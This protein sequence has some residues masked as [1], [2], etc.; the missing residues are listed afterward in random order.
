[1]CTKTCKC[2]DCKNHEEW[3]SIQ[4]TADRFRSPATGKAKNF[5]DISPVI[6]RTTPKYCA[7]EN[8]LGISK[9]TSGTEI[10]EVKTRC[11]FRRKVNLRP[12]N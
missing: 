7:F 12:G 2:T 11:E 9:R 5:N 3:R 8:S 1:M 10:K 6:H 4:E